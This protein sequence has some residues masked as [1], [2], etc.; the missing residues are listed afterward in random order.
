MLYC[1]CSGG[2]ETLD[3]EMHLGVVI[4][5]ALVSQGLYT[6]LTFAY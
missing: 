3:S 6:I 4:N 1:Y 5:G 2:T